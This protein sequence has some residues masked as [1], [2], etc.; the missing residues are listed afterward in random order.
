MECMVRKGERLKSSPPCWE[1]ENSLP[2]PAALKVDVLCA[3]G[4]GGSLQECG[5]SG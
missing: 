1:G 5:L 2:D 4:Y 3:Q